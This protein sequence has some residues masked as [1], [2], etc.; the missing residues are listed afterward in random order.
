MIPRL[1]WLGL[2]YLF[3]A[4]PIGVAVTTLW[5]PGT[6]VR[7]AGSGN[8]GATNVA[9]VAGWRLGLAVLGL[10]FLKGAVPVLFT[11]LLWPGEGRAFAALVAAVAF[12][13]HCWPVYLEFR[14]GK[15][16][17]TAAGALA[18]LSPVVTAVGALAWGAVLAATGRASVAS[19]SSVGAVVFSALLVDRAIL[20]VALALAVAIVV[21]H[22]SNLARLADGTEDRVAARRVEAAVDP[23][24]WLEQGPDGRPTGRGAWR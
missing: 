2:A 22:A 12:A 1:V 9:R 23:Q 11:L 13:G 16:V 15:G 19:L 18:A 20:P 21:R 4:L 10:D 24:T 6:D 7:E 5:G 14:G 17:A 3:A 8:V